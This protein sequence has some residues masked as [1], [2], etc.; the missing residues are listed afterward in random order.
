[1]NKEGQPK[2]PNVPQQADSNQQPVVTPESIFQV[3]N[4]NRPRFRPDSN[5]QGAS[6]EDAVETGR[7]LFEA[8]ERRD[9]ENVTQ[10][11]IVSTN[12]PIE[13]RPSQPPQQKPPTSG[14]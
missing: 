4:P 10:Q 9:R 3:S 7:K 2:S 8:L 14:K 13:Q 5:L 11:G 12:Q 6:K 1:M